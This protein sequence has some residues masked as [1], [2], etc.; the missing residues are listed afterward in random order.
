ME[1]IHSALNRSTLADATAGIALPAYDRDS[2]RTGIVHLGLGAFHRAHQA[3]YTDTLLARGDTRW[4]IVGVHLRERR[5]AD[6]LA[7]QDYL[8]SVTERDGG[9]ARSRIVGSLRGALYAPDALP[10]VLDAI[11]DPH[12]AIVSLTV[13]E[14]G[15]N[16]APASADLDAD[17]AGIRHDVAEPDA[18]RTTLGV[19][20]AGLRR[21]PA[22]APLTIVCCD[23]MMAN[24]DTL[25]RLL[26]QFTE[27]GDPALA[28]RIAESIAFPNTMVDRIVPAS[29]A[30]SL[31]DAQARIG[32][33]DDAAIV[34][35]PFTQWVIED[36]FS[37]PRPAWEDAG[38]LVTHDVHPYEAMKLRLLNGSH[39]AIAYVGQLRGRATVSDAMADPALAAFVER[40]MTEDL[41]PTVTVPAGYDAHAYCRALLERFRNPT[42]AHQTRQI[43][44]DGTQKV[45]VRWLPALRE[46]VAA[47]IERPALERALAAWLHYLASGRSDAGEPLTISDPGADALGSR[48]RAASHAIEAVQAAFAQTGVFGATP[49][50]A[51]FV[52][53]IAGHLSA[54]REHGTAA[55]LTPARRA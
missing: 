54:L 12:V 55:L 39:S 29:T 2:V 35:E 8:Y 27:L 51:A 23:N 47:G 42:L 7:A 19:L 20:A 9:T 17:D 31:A 33:R 46:S 13:T 45:P 34:C 28:R 50:P 40:V 37:G 21:R 11:A 32:L 16:L 25:R 26:L 10:R 5:M 15:Y 38:A 53:R 22:N 41:L 48:L 52:E 24:G 3:L 4:G 30:A 18:P 36:R 1:K 44:M 49:W 43:A 14:K 6:V